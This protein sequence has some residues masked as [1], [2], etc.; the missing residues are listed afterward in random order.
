MEIYR[1]YFQINEEATV[2]DTTEYDSF[3]AAESKMRNMIAEQGQKMNIA[4]YIYAIRKGKNRSYRKIIADALTNIF[5]E[6]E[7]LSVEKIKQMK[8]AIEDLTFDC[9]FGEKE[10]TAEFEAYTEGGRIVIVEFNFDQKLHVEFDINTDF[11]YNNDGIIGSYFFIQDR[12]GKFKVN[13]DFDVKIDLPKKK[14][15]SSSI[16]FVYNGLV[17]DAYSV[18]K[19]IE[20]EHIAPNDVLRGITPQKIKGINPNISVETINNHI[21]TLKKLG[22]PIKRYKVSK[23]EKEFWKARNIRCNEGY[24]I[25]ID[26]LDKVPEPVDAS[27]LGVHANPLLILF[28]IK[29]ANRPMRQA[30]IIEALREKYN[31]EIGRA[32]VGR[33]IELLISF[34]YDIEKSKDGYILKK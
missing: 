22:I 16:I 21:N 20:E 15:N 27:E 18:K 33:H 1:V 26:F 28:V 30:D 4:S 3:W 6:A 23:E 17:N 11:E 25:D 32:A 8:D 10:P 31:V 13:V 29:T 2:W 7:P 9:A 14:S 12:N 24:E 5:L 19:A 34:G